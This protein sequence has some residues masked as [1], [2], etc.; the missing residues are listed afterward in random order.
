MKSSRNSNR[1][2]CTILDIDSCDFNWLNGS[3]GTPKLTLG[4]T[5]PSYVETDRVLGRIEG[6]LVGRIEG[7][8]VKS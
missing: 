2:A 3:K 1:T 4:C 8:L 5:E 7:T 6:T